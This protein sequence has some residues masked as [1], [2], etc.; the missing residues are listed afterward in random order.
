[1][2]L[3]TAHLRTT[4]V[5]LSVLLAAAAACGQVTYRTVALSGDPAPGTSPQEFFKSFGPPTINNADQVMFHATLPVVLA[6]NDLGVWSEG[7]GV[8]D[9][10]VREGNAAPGAPVGAAF[11]EFRSP[12]INDAGQTAF[13]GVLRLGPGGVTFDNNGG[14]WLSGSGALDLVAF[15]SNPAPGLPAGIYYGRIADASHNRPFNN[16]GHTAFFTTL[17]GSVVDGNDSAFFSQATGTMTVLAREGSHAPGTPAGANYWHG[18][19]IL[20]IA[21]ND[22]GQ[23]AFSSHLQ[24]GAGGVDDTNNSGIWTGTPGA[25][26]LVAREGSH[27]PGT[28]GGTNFGT[29]LT[30]GGPTINN[31]GQVAFNAHLAPG[32]GVTPKNDEGLWCGTPGSLRLV[33]REGQHAPGTPAG[34][35]FG[36]GGSLVGFLGSAS[37]NTAGAMAFSAQLEPGSGGVIEDDNDWGIWSEGFGSPELVARTGSQAPDAPAGAVFDFL[38]PPAMNARGQVAFRAGLRIGSG[39]VTVDNYYGLW[40]QDVDGTLRLVLRMGD[41]FEVAPGD[42]RIVKEFITWDGTSNEDGGLSIFNDNGTVTFHADFT[43]G[44][45]GVFAATVP[46]PA[47]SALLL[48]GALALIRRKRR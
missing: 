26:E 39:G 12:I 7:T 20:P 28:P 17:S 33:V 21:M 24:D 5:V 32:A 4:T 8:L 42:V 15:E 27:A 38:H 16:A 6:G 22:S 40:V 19:S 9:L 10:V 2:A 23:A 36:D 45:S 1:M 37:L 31:A 25:V 11:S 13:A 47:T 41:P 14:I 18:S 34:A 3:H 46:E 29:G 48:T 44:T 30:S 35:N 43:D